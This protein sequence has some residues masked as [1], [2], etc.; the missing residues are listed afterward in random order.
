MLK[1][2]NIN[3]KHFRK[4][5]IELSKTVIEGLLSKKVLKSLPY[6]VLFKLK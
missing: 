1:Y 3:C 6:H 2:N 5:Y 4:M